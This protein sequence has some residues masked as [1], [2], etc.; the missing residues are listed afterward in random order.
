MPS[1]LRWRSVRF[2]SEEKGAPIDTDHAEDTK[3][4]MAHVEELPES[5]ERRRHEA[6]IREAAEKKQKSIKDAHVEAECGN[7]AE[8]AD[9]DI[10]RSRGSTA[11]SPQI[12]IGA[13]A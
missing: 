4:D 2:I 5:Q 9:D 6:Q 10:P 7:I 12:E 11:A 3:Q 13:T 8:H 1:C